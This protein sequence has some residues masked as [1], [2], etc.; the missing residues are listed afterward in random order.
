MIFPINISDYEKL[1]FHEQYSY[2]HNY[3]VEI[4]KQVSISIDHIPL[5]IINSIVI[6]I[7]KK[8]E[9]QEKEIMNKFMTY[10]IDIY[11]FQNMHAYYKDIYA[12]TRVCNILLSLYFNL[13]DIEEHLIYEICMFVQQYPNASNNLILQ[14]I[15]QLQNQ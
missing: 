8:P 2:A 14:K 13:Y 15:N 10:P 11:N 4:F 7:Q 9:V 5:D 12:S 3:L 1:P 6:F